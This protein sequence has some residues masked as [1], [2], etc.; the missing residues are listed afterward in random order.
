MQLSHV[1]QISQGPIARKLVALLEINKS[2]MVHLLALCG[3]HIDWSEPGQAS[4]D[5]CLLIIG[6]EF[7]FKGLAILVFLLGVAKLEL[8]ELRVVQ[9]GE[10]VRLRLDAQYFIKAWNGP[11]IA[12]LFL[13]LVVEDNLLIV[14]LLVVHRKLVLAVICNRNLVYH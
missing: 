9:L 8:V 1:V 7:G 11:V 3:G 10:V 5:Q 12:Y 14:V 13:I 4:L 2:L 6:D